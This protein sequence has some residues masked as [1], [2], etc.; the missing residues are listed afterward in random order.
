[1]RE[2]YKGRMGDSFTLSGFHEDLLEV[3]NMPPVL[4]REGLMTN[5]PSGT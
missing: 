3:G 1:M 5:L 4:M 2:E